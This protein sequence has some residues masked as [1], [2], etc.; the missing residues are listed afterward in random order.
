M[1]IRYNGR[2]YMFREYDTKN[3]TQYEL[4]KMANENGRL[5][6]EINAVWLVIPG[7]GYG[8]RIDE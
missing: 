8:L 2:L 7:I 1:S 5:Q 6:Y 3:I 4:Q